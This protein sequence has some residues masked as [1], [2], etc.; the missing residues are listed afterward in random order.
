M[1]YDYFLW[2]DM[3]SSRLENDQFD[4]KEPK[5]CMHCY[6]SGPQVKLGCYVTLGNHDKAEGIALYACQLCGSTSIHYLERSGDFHDPTFTPISSIPI[7]KENIQDITS[8]FRSMF[9]NFYEI[10]S[11]SLTAEEN[12][13]D[14]IAGMGYRKALEF[15][16]TDYLIAYPVEGAEEEWLTNP[17]TTLSKKISKLPSQRIQK[18]AKAIS[19]LGNDETHYSRQHPEHDIQSI[20]AFTRALIS[21]I[22]NEIEL[23]RAEALLSKPRP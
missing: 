13:L 9:P 14:Q 15:L 22:Q 3:E 23:Q 11:Q 2:L 17:K 10:Y 12:D 19:F 4:I 6:T 18:L 5:Q 8:Q 16:V 7:L 1:S 21:E 20:K